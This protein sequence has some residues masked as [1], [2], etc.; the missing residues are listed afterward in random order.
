MTIKIGT[1]LSSSACKVMMLGSGELGKEVVIELRML[2]SVFSKSP[3][4]TGR[5]ATGWRNTCSIP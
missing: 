3:L 4:K 1:P 5:S 2:S